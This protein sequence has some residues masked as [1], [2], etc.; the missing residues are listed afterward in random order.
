MITAKTFGDFH[1]SNHRSQTPDFSI[2][3]RQRQSIYNRVD[4]F[5]KTRSSSSRLPLFFVVLGICVFCWGLGY[6][7]SLYDVHE[8]SI[9]RIPEAKLMSRNE[10]PNA[11]DSLRLCLARSVS[12][13]QASSGTF[14]V[15][16]LLIGSLTGP[17]SALERQRFV[18]SKPWRPRS[19]A[20]LSAFFLRPPPV[21]SGL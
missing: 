12:L 6:K 3:C 15:L 18:L 16:F 17:T 11:T 7:L 19:A 9:H 5:S 20:I 4:E 1:L 21:L 13:E 2:A 14:A 10:D 8:S